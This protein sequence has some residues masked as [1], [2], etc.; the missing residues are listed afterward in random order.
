MKCT[1]S[2]VKNGCKYAAKINSFRLLSLTRFFSPNTSLTLV[3]FL[4]FHCQN[5]DFQVFHTSGNPVYQFHSTSWDVSCAGRFYNRAGH[6]WMKYALTE[7]RMRWTNRM[8][9]VI[10][11][12]ES[13]I[14]MHHFKLPTA[15]TLVSELKNVLHQF[16]TLLIHTPTRRALGRAHYL[17]QWSLSDSSV[18]VFVVLDLDLELLQLT[19]L[20][21]VWVKSGYR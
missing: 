15:F 20:F 11:W 13:R 18:N 7:G 10:D 16:T 8:A 14:G 9:D 12:F 4:T 17:R 3:K 5:P 19:Q 1:N 2:A 21:R 6:C